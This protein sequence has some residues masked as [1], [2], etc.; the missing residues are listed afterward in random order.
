MIRR[1]YL[2][3]LAILF[4]NVA[5]AFTP[6]TGPDVIV[7]ELE[8]VRI[9]TRDSGD[10]GLFVTTVSCNVGNTPINWFSLHSPDAGRRS[11]HPVITQGFY[12]LANSRLEQ[13]GQSGVKH[14]FTALQNGGLCPLPCVPNPDGTRLG[15]GC[16]D[17]YVGGLIRD[18]QDIGLRSAINP[19]TGQF[20]PTTAATPGSSPFGREL[21]VHA[22]DVTDNTARYFV[23]GEYIAAD[24]SRAGNSRNNVSY[25]EVHLPSDPAG[26]DLPPIGPTR[27]GCPAVLAWDGARFTATGWNA[28][29]HII[30]AV[31]T[32]HVAGT[33]YLVDVGVYNLDSDNGVRGL[34]VATD[35]LKVAPAGIG[36][37]SPPS[38][39]EAFSS[40]P[41]P[42]KVSQHQV[43]WQGPS[44]DRDHA[45][46]AIRWGQLFN[47]WFEANSPSA[48]DIQA[49]TLLPFKS[50]A[51][52]LVVK[53]NGV[54]T[55]NPST[56]R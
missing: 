35:N 48:P 40:D 55:C 22:T 41:W 7:A 5:P 16:S 42:S 9:V 39:G 14:G 33:T 47:F 51:A 34:T 43:S 2:F 3:C 37:Y 49:I 6:T 17:P 8:Q 54:L 36:F 21:R 13:I 32:T 18:P 28:D 26:S 31:K 30:V 52:P 53:P 1:M 27:R 4:S 12:R 56:Y 46:N 25:M 44:Y 11:D 24:D 38:F 50:A 10:L 19:S 29:G 45:A 15:V 20:D 23:E